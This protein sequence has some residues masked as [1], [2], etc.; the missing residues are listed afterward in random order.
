[1]CRDQTTALD[2]IQVKS[3]LELMQIYEETMQIRKERD[4]FDRKFREVSEDRDK[5]KARLKKYRARRA[6]YVQDQKT[7]RNCGKEYLESENFN[8]SCRTHPSDFGGEMYWCCGK[9]GRDAP[10]CKYRKHI[11]KK[12][13]TLS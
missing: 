2:Q 10:G 11:S 1:M 6:L 4:F 7:C 9:L 5:I 13:L 12:H 8:W 3:R